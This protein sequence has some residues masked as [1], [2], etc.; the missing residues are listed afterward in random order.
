[1]RPSIVLLVFSLVVCAACVYDERAPT[2]RELVL[3]AEVDADSPIDVI[4]RVQGLPREQLSI[5]LDATLGTFTPDSRDVIADAQGAA[6]IT[7]RYVSPKGGMEEVHVSVAAA[8]GAQDLETR[9]FRVFN[10]TRIG[11]TSATELF[12]GPHIAGQLI[13][14]PISLTTPQ[15]IRRLGVISPP[16]TPAVLVDAQLGIYTTL[17]STSISVLA[18]TSAKLAAGHNEIEIP[19]LS[20]PEGVYWFVIAYSGTPLVYRSITNVVS[21]RVKNGVP[22]SEGLADTITGL[23]TTPASPLDS[24]M[25]FYQRAQYVV[26]RQ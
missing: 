19:P 17:S 1:M 16:V 15:V 21:M 4:I 7:A 25:L 2:I 11:T 6:E 14:Y 10:V 8:S 18:K 3:P 13:A 12:H 22:Y 26:A 20:L 9:T 23:A 5:V 24:G